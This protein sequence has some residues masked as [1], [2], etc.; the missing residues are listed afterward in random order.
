MNF[1]VEGS[2][3]DLEAR[4]AMLEQAAAMPGYKL[5]KATAEEKMKELGRKLAD[6]STEREALELSKEALVWA[7]GPNMLEA[8]IQET[9]KA[10]SNEKSVTEVSYKQRKLQELEDKKS[11]AS[12][13]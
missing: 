13:L 9:K 6:V 7:V 11:G 10:I 1:E 8:M 12:S 3:S 2:L 4:L 5:L